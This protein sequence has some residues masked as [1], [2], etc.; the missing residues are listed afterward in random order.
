M[1]THI[2]TISKT[3]PANHSNTGQPT[4][5]EQ[6]IKTGLTT[7]DAAYDN[8]KLHTIRGN[9]PLW[10]KKIDEVIAGKAILSVREWSGKPYASKQKVLF[11]FD[12]TSGIGVEELEFHKDK[13]DIPSIKYPIINNFAEPN[14]YEL[15]HNDGLSTISFKEWFKNYD[16]SQPMAI[17]HFTKFRY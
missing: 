4:Y 5:F 2:L 11:E 1:K 16:L 13:D 14:L 3:F 6:R 17:I 10:K 7:F 9:Y 12:H 8:Y 15:A